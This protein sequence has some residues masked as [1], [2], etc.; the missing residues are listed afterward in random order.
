MSGGLGRSA[1]ATTEEHLDPRLATILVVESSSA[2]GIDL[3]ERLRGD[4]YRATLACTASHARALACAVPV[5]AVI[6]GALGQAGEALD[7]LGEIRSTPAHRTAWD[8]RLPVIMLSPSGG[9]LD[10]LRAFEAGADDFIAYPG[11]YPE[12]RVRLASLL[13]RVERHQASPWRIGPLQIDTTMR[14]VRVASRQ[15]ELAPREYELLLALA[16]KPSRVCSR[17]ELLREVWGSGHGARVRTVDSHASR[18]R[19]KLDAA[20]A[21]GL[22]TSIWGVGYRLL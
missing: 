21:E 10:L 11:S 1:S 13:R 18:L 7:L 5:R 22:V 2:N 14:R 3:V 12:L 6:L 4:G 20:G 19:R 17:R 15:L 16:R 8:A 9:Q